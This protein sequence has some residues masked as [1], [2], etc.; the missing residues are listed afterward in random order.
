MPNLIFGQGILQ[1]VPYHK[2]LGITI[3]KNYKWDEHV[4]RIVNK[5]NLHLCCLRSYTYKLSRKAL[6]TMYKSFFL[7]IFDYADVIW[8]S[9]S[10]KKT[11]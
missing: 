3:Q 6:E 10:K 2:H 11:F 4:K 8:D 5:V 7:P 1:E 9:C